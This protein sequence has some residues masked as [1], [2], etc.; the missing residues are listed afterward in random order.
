M[1]NDGEFPWNLASF[2]VRLLNH[3]KWEIHCLAMGNSWSA[4]SHEGRFFEIGKLIYNL[5][6]YGLWGIYRAGQWFFLSNKDDCGA[7]PWKMCLSVF[8]IFPQDTPIR[9]IYIY[10]YLYVLR[11]FVAYSHTYSQY[12][13]HSHC[14]VIAKIIRSIF[15]RDK[16]HTLRY[17]AAYIPWFF[18]LGAMN[19]FE[20][21]RSGIVKRSEPGESDEEMLFMR[22]VRWLRGGWEG[23]GMLF[24]MSNY[25]YIYN[26]SGWSVWL[27]RKMVSFWMICLIKDLLKIG[28]SNPNWR[29]HIFYIYLFL[30]I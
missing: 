27:Y 2:L 20:N 7:S 10:T 16:F 29:T 1:F 14:E 18:P 25:N 4:N 22:T 9:Y 23:N 12:H 30:L 26:L 5:T 6:N 15:L 17:I 19:L 3:K 21:P 8:W 13:E 28:N 11:L 24:F